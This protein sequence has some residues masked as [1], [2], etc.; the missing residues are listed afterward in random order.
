MYI[1]TSIHRWRGYHR[2]V[3]Q[4]YCPVSVL[5]IS[6][7]MGSFVVEA[8]LVSLYSRR[9]SVRNALVCRRRDPVPARQ[10]TDQE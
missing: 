9:S 5:R 7:S 1:S 2:R 6:R 10:H 8:I 3:R 4:H